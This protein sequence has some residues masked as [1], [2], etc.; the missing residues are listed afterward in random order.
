MFNSKLKNQL[1]RLQDEI[2]AL[3]RAQAARTLE[4]LEITVDR[5]L[6]ITAVNRNFARWVGREQSQLLGQSLASIAPSYVKE[7]PCF[8]DFQQAMSTGTGVSDEYRYITAD[9]RMVWMRAAWCP[10]LRHRCH[11][12]HR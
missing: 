1:Q 7:L 2:D 11:R 8:K 3:Q 12:E 10:V 4:M 9:G 5:N 6:L